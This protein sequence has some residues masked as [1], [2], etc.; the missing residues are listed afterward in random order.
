MTRSNDKS[1]IVE[2]YEIVSQ[3]YK[4][5]WGDHIH[6]G[7]WVH[8]NETKEQAQELL[9]EHLAGLAGIKP[10]SRLLDIGCGFG[11]SSLFLARTMGVSAVGI[12][13]SP[14]QVRMANE[15]AAQQGL[16]AHFN[17]MDA[18]E[19]HFDECFDV[20][21]SVE[22]ISH[23]HNRSRFFG[24]ALPYLKAG[25]TF[26]L[27]DWF[28]RPGLSDRETRRFI[29]P[30]ERSMFVELDTMNDYQNYLE[31]SSCQI[32]HREILNEHC[33]RSW[34]VGLDIIK[35]KAFWKVA[36]LHGP[37]FVKNLR[38]FQAMR[39]GFASGSF[40]YGLFVAKQPL[41]PACPVDS[42]IYNFRNVS[43]IGIAAL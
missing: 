19:P 11:G 7:Y 32:V 30:I 14:V 9:I 36:M 33:A 39:D 38:G 41:G 16:D 15:A 21:W 25:G 35:E 8:G 28:K 13:I 29:R 3:Y 4:S 1:K 6:H 2:H 23:Y 31:A 17:L 22:S 26:A 24:R 40:V 37:D 18:E 43:P 10:G 42:S 34:D 12:T 5:L 27:T 20:L